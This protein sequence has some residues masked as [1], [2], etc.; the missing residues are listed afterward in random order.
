MRSK[1]FIVAHQPNPRKNEKK[2]PKTKDRCP[3]WNVFTS[4]VRLFFLF[5]FSFSSS[6]SWTNCNNYPDIIFTFRKKEIKNQKEP[7]R[8]WFIFL[9]FFLFKRKSM[10][11]LK[12]NSTTFV[13]QKY[14]CY[15]FL[16]SERFSEKCVPLIKRNISIAAIHRESFFFSFFT[17]HALTHKK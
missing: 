7:T 12:L 13:Y 16:Y 6:G 4:Q 10:W 15:R 9:Y 5:L 11:W 14:T 3:S 2:N 8:G 1:F 17:P